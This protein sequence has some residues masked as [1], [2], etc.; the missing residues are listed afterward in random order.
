MWNSVHSSLS[1]SAEA[2]NLGDVWIY[3]IYIKAFSK[4]P[5]DRVSVKKTKPPKTEIC[6]GKL[7]FKNRS[8]KKRNVSDTASLFLLT[9]KTQKVTK[10]NIHILSRLPAST[11][12]NEAVCVAKFAARTYTSFHCLCSGLIHTAYH[13]PT[14]TAP[15]PQLSHSNFSYTDVVLSPSTSYITC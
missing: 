4:L 11:P 6:A 5:H 1:V 10:R 9:T 8:S 7:M 2:A 13:P 3:I 14:V 15:H 12:G